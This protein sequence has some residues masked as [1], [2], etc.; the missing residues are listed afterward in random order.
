MPLQG[1]LQIVENANEEKCRV[2]SAV[3]PGMST[4]TF[5]PTAR[6]EWLSR[7]VRWRSALEGALLQL[8]AWW[9]IMDIVR[10]T[11]AEPGAK[12]HASIHLVSRANRNLELSIKPSHLTTMPSN[13]IQT[14]FWLRQMESILEE[15]NEGVIIVD[16]Q[17]HIVFVNE[18]LIQLGRYKR[19]EIQGHTPAAIFPQEDLPYIMR[20]HEL[21]QRYGRHRNEFYFP[22]KDGEKI[23]AIFSGRVIKGPDGQEYILLTVTDI[24]AQKRVEEQLRDT[25][26]LLEKRQMEI[27]AELAVAARVQQTLA[28]R[29]LVWSDLAVETYYSPARTIGGDFSVIQPQGDEFLNLVVCDVSGH[30]AGS[31]L[32]A[33]R[34]YSETFHTL[35]ERIRPSSL[36]R[37]LHD[38]VHD[39]IGVDGFYFTMAAARFSQHGHRVTFAAAAQPPAILVSNGVLRRLDSQNGILGCLTETA[40]SGS[41]DDIDLA[42]GDRLLLYT[43]G[44]VEVFNQNHEMLGVQ[45]LARLVRESATQPLQQM[46]QT[47]LEGV[48]TWRNGPLADDISLVIVEV[49]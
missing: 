31:A 11:I 6:R 43:D 22:R 18:A 42:T 45:G 23:P 3:C 27:D 30:G 46:K 4:L 12:A 38:F 21:G 29:N 7:N 49:R 1:S 26:V 5:S 25:N 16:E 15:L 24:S 40:P 34:I 33:N 44:L 36:L 41:A 35:E 39:Y 48:A 28:P 17:L 20:Q 8:G 19:D 37:R 10:A 13:V 2:G 32:L 9:R 14:P 47:I